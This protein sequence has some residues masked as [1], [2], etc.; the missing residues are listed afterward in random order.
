MVG[1]GGQITFD[2]SQ[3]L[4]H[5]QISLHGS[6]VTSIGHMEELTQNLVRWR[7]NPEVIVSHRFGLD[8]AAEA[9]RIA[10]DGQS[11]KV[12]IVMN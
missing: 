6:W 5:P 9:Y 2:V 11:G 8:A 1:E 10:D 3:L 7:L 12:C 4:I